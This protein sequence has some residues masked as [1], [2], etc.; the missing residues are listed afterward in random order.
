MEISLYNE[1]TSEYF[2]IIDLP[3][4]IATFIMKDAE[5]NGYNVEEYIRQIIM[6]TV[7]DRV[8]AMGLRNN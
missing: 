2:G 4:D 5:F 6:E 3:D 1:D 7:D 8:Q